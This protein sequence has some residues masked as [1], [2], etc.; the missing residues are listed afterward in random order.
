MAGT[1]NS[2]AATLSVPATAAVEWA[3]LYWSGNNKGGSSLTATA[4]TPDDQVK[5]RPPGASKY[6]T[7]T[8][9][10]C[11][12]IGVY[13][14]CFEDV[15]AAVTAAGSGEYMVADISA[16]TGRNDFVGG[17]ELIV[18]YRDDGAD[19]RSVAIHHGPPRLRRRHLS[20]LHLR[21]FPDTTERPG[22]GLD[23]RVGQRG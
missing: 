21:R 8:G 10:W 2:S 23:Q 20:Q 13:F 1:Y 5:F 7:I 4:S 22:A 19:L 14:Q 17:W 16:N 15:T 11:S 6:T 9:D 18:V 3:G 12:T